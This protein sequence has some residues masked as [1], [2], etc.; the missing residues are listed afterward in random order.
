MSSSSKQSAEKTLPKE[1][2]IFEALPGNAVRML[3]FMSLSGSVAACTATAATALSQSSGQ[4]GEGDLGLLSLVLA[5]SISVASTVAVTKM[6]GPF[7]TRIKLLPTART[8]G[9]QIDKHGLPKFDSILSSASSASGKA[10]GRPMLSGSITGDTEIVLES[11][12]LLG[13]NTRSTQL[14]IGDLEPAARR[15]RTWNLTDVAVK[16]RRQQGVSTPLKTFTI[17]WKSIRNSPGK[18]LMQEIDSLVGSR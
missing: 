1:Q 2:V 14:K 9:V 5:S 12:G 13:F 7:V 10:Q 3:K 16:Q 11:P 15:F 8:R 4:L 6:F 17:M 18:K